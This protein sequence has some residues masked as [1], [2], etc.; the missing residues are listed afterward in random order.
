MGYPTHQ[1]STGLW[2]LARRQHWVVSH[3]Q[4]IELGY[5]PQAIKHRVHRG[6]LHRIRRGVYAVGR[7]QLSR[8]GQ[9]MAA[10]LCCGRGAVLSHQTAAALWRIRPHAGRLIDVSVPADRTPA[11]GGIDVHRRT[12][13]G[14]PARRDGIPLTS[15]L[16]TLIDLATVLGEPGLEAAVNEADRLELI[17]P[18]TLRASLARSRGRPGVAV[19]ARLLDRTTFTL[20]DS[21]LERLF[22]PII[23]AAGLPT[24][25][26]QEWVN[27]YRV[28][29]YWPR[30]GLVVETDGLRYHRTATQQSRDQR[31]DQAHA[32]S[33]LTPVR[34]SHAQVAFDPASVTA[35]LGEIAGR[36]SRD[37]TC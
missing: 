14:P 11:H 37:L 33:G 19:L 4:L 23:A 8:E 17:D 21:E 16:Y 1:S 15:P 20:T 7:S 36:L 34:F 30:L 26:T 13:L 2:R 28:D 12:E 29:F 24:P 9:W 32:A 25:A 3:R 18:E 31:R 10:V 27:G 6:R 22:L 5:S 35:T